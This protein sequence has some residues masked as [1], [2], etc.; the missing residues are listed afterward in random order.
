MLLAHY[1]IILVQNPLSKPMPEILLRNMHVHKQMH[2]KTRNFKYK[3]RGKV[4]LKPMLTR[5]SLNSR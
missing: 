1:I 4:I 2:I 5:V 3:F